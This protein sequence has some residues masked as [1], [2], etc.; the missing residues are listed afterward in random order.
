MRGTYF[1]ITCVLS[2]YPDGR[3]QFVLLAI[4]AVVAYWAVTRPG[5][6]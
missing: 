2:R 1:R 3:M 5:G 6:G 4:F